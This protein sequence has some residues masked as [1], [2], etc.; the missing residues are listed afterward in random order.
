MRVRKYF[1][2][3]IVHG[4]DTKL[5]PHIQ[6][7]MFCLIILHTGNQMQIEKKRMNSLREFNLRVK[8]Q[9]GG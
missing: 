9:M 7:E 2:S 4:D 3:T 5:K 1:V 8:W 6:I